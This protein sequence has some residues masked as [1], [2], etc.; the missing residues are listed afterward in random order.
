MPVKLAAKSGEQ[1][2]K[3]SMQRMPRDIFV[4]FIKDGG[5]VLMCG[6]CM[7]EFGLKLDDLI[8]GVQM[9]GLDTR[10][11]SFLRRAHAP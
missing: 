3:P 2:K 1:E 6:P 10:R 4:D 9:G 7:T 11:V 8:P 5:T